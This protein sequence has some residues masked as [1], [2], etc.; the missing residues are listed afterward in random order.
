M[1]DN[2]LS[3]DALSVQADVGN[4]GVFVSCKKKQIL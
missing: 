1:Q 2:Q 3:T 4:G